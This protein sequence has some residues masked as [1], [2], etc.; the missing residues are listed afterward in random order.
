M[1]HKTQLEIHSDECD[2]CHLPIE[3][4]S[5]AVTQEDGE[6]VLTFC[7]DDCMKQYLADPDFFSEF[8]DDEVLE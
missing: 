1:T 5:A 7:S 3:D 6:Y 2:V 8:D 4:L